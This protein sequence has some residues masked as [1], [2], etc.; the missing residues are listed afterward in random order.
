MVG[1]CRGVEL[2]VAGTLDLRSHP[3]GRLQA[4]GIGEELGELLPIRFLVDDHSDSRATPLGL[5]VRRAEVLERHDLV[6]LGPE[7]DP[8]LLVQAPEDVGD[9][10]PPDLPAHAHPRGL[11]GAVGERRDDRSEAP[12]PRIGN[13]GSRGHDVAVLRACRHPG[14][15]FLGDDLLAWLVLALGG[16]LFAGNVAAIARP[17]AEPREEGALDRAPLVRSVLMGGLGLVAAIWALA[18]LLSG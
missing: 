18:S 13:V 11:L 15:V 1:T 3:G 12:D 7:R 4:E 2:D 8:E 10:G 9:G 14:D 6:G 5:E 17:P 16:A